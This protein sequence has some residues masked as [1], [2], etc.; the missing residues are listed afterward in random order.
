MNIKEIKPL[1]L[2]SLPPHPNLAHCVLECTEANVVHKGDKLPMFRDGIRQYRGFHLE[3]S[4]K[5]AVLN[6]FPNE[7]PYEWLRRNLWNT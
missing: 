2:L 4:S 7:L 5:V 6:F 3:F 1:I